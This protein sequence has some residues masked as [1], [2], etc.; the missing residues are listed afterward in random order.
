[1]KENRSLLRPEHAHK[2]PPFA[3]AQYTEAAFSRIVRLIWTNASQDTRGWYALGQAQN[4]DN[5][6]I[7]WMLYHVCRYR[8]NRN[9]ARATSR[10]FHDD[11]NLDENAGEDKTHPITLGTLSLQ[12]FYVQGRPQRQPPLQP[13]ILLL[14]ITMQPEMDIVR[15]DSLGATEAV[16][17]AEGKPMGLYEFE[18]LWLPVIRARQWIKGNPEVPRRSNLAPFSKIQK[19]R[20]SET[21]LVKRAS[22]VA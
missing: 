8:D 18:L 19:H 22:E 11:D 2:P 3:A 7:L 13:C 14:C 6:V 20:S 16:G 15:S 1:M 9:K 21:I 10:N 12:I 17:L 4:G 5:W